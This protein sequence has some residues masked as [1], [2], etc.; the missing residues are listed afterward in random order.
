MENPEK[1]LESDRC[2]SYRINLT[3]SGVCQYLLAHSV[4]FIL[5]NENIKA[6]SCQCNGYKDNIRSQDAINYV[7]K[8][9]VQISTVLKDENFWKNLSPQSS[10]PSED[11]GRRGAHHLAVELHTRLP[12]LSLSHGHPHSSPHLLIMPSVLYSVTFSSRKFIRM[13]VHESA[14]TNQYP[15]PS[16]LKMK[17]YLW[18]TFWNKL[19]KKI[20]LLIKEYFNYSNIS[21]DQRLYLTWPNSLWTEKCGIFFLKFLLKL[22]FVNVQCNVCFTWTKQWFSTLYDT[23]VSIIRALLNAHRLFAPIPPTHPLL[24]ISLFYR[25]KIGFLVCLFSLC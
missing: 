24:T 22:Q 25:V 13:W 11:E 3:F 4:T 10:L 9:E 2:V 7:N 18:L 6:W 12:R 17:A 21:N 19:Q 23:W 20:L 8:A 14:C 15:T 5:L 16:T 1:P